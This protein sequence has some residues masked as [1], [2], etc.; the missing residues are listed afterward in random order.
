MGQLKNEVFICLDCEMTGL[1]LENDRI[2]EVAAVRF[3]IDEILETFSTLVNPECPISNEALEIHK[4]SQEMVANAPKIEEIL[5]TL[6]KIMERYPIVGHGVEF[7][8]KMIKKAA[9]RLKFNTIIGNSIVIDTLR[10]ARHYGDSPSNSL[11][12]LA[13]HFNVS[14]D[15]SHRA[16][17]DVQVNIEVFKLLIHNR[18]SN[19]DQILKLLSFPIKMKTMPLGKHKGR[20]FNEIPLQYLQWAANMDFDQDLLYSIRTELKRR[21]KGGGFGEAAN[22]FSDLKVD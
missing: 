1:D 5:P 3:T 7:D 10:L 20:L 6:F 22:P 4:I 16:L 12:T 15:E 9:E 14:F 21:K 17:A 8:I 2:I 18:F 13:R 11:E 19:L